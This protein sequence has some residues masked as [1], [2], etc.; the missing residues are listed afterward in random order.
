MLTKCKEGVFYQCIAMSV[1]VLIQYNGR[2]RRNCLSVNALR[3][4]EKGEEE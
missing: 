3:E 1:S 2:G 4:K